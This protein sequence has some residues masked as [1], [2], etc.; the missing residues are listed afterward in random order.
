MPWALRQA[1]FTGRS[2]DLK[3]SQPLLHTDIARLKQGKVG[4]QV[5]TPSSRTVFL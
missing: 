1:A 3:Q 4:A 5:L 2:L